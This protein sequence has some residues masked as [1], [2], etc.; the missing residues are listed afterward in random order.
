MAEKNNDKKL[1]FKQLVIA[2]W[3]GETGMTYSTLALGEDGYVYRYD[4]KCQGW[5][6]WSMVEATC[7]ED[8]PGK[9]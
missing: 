8:H 6:Q 7:R 5:I 9:R 1:K 4:P 3:E 2:Q